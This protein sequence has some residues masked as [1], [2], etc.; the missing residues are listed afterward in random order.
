M[1][2]S[3]LMQQLVAAA[4][5]PDDPIKKGFAVRE[6]P[7]VLLVTTVDV[8]GGV[9]ER[10]E[11]RVGEI[12]EDVARAFCR[13]YNL[14]DA[15]VGPLAAHLE[16]NL[17]KAAGNRDGKPA[18]E[19]AAAGSDGGGGPYDPPHRTRSPKRH[20][21]T[22][23]KPSG[24][25]GGVGVAPMAGNA[26]PTK[27]SFGTGM[28]ERLYQQLSNKLLDES[29]APSTR[30]GN[31]VSASEVLSGGGGGGGSGHNSKRS[32]SGISNQPTGFPY[33][34][35]T[36]VPSP[37]ER[38]SVHL[39]LYATAQER[40]ARLEERRRVANAEAVAAL[41]QRRSAMSWIS[42]EM[43]RGR[44]A[45]GAYD[46]YGEMLYA[47][48]VEAL[49]ARLKRAEAERKAREARE[50]EGVTFAPAITKKAWE[51]KQRERSNCL[52]SM[53][54]GMDGGDEYEKWQR[55]H[56]RGVRKSTQE[57]LEQLRQQREAAEVAECT[58]RPQINKNSD[59]LM[60]ERSEALK[61]LNLTHYEQLF[62]DAQ[63]R[64]VKLEDLR[65]WY[66]E[67]V[68]FQPQVN[69]DPRALEYLRRSWDKLKQQQQQQQQQQRS[70][71]PN[72]SGAATT[73]TSGCN[74]GLAGSR[75]PAVVTRL[76][77]EA[78][79]KQA[80]LEAA[81][82]AAYGAV[83]PITQK[84]PFPARVRPG[85]TRRHRPRAQQ[86]PRRAHWGAPVSLGT[87]PGGQAGG[88]GGGGAAGGD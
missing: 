20:S 49:M 3:D 6:E 66:P 8:G 14:P 11:V 10:I 16:E 50:L 22:Q 37:R 27:Y 17:R 41:T 57:R 85:A 31:W 67:G 60:M 81:R 33:G 78:G 1:M 42:A 87:G 4:A 52:N 15:I 28:D 73:S 80:K 36:A 58:F 56:M 5:L 86:P 83:D 45:N 43:M 40:A 46:N 68:T 59:M 65:N 79:R 29:H 72:V 74:Q 84:T 9:S 39:R 38:D 70:P 44:G 63:R 30:R 12:P 47:E 53:S 24:G 76:Y 26:Q 62:A 19:G 48:G 75:V 23:T 82:Q 35:T 32:S 7:R 54:N 21:P 55:L 13:R 34:K 77:A 25:I 88:C 69:K 64:Q 71:G 2:S 61:Q 18:L 51:L